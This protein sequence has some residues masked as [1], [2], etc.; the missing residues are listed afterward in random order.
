MKP[1]DAPL[2]PPSIFLSPEELKELTDYETARY[3]KAWLDRHGYT[4]E[5]SARGRPKVLRAYVM[6]RMGLASAAPLKH[7]EPD[8]SKWE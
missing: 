5:L 1:N 7:T 6:Q 4:Y 3:Q 2:I 8:F